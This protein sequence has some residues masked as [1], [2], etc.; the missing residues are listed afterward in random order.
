M[1]MEISTY[2]K[3]LQLPLF[4]GLSKDDL[5]HIISKAKLHFHKCAVHET[6]VEQGKPC[7]QLIFLLNG[8]LLMQSTDSQNA[9]TLSEFLDQPC[10]IEPYSLFGMSPYYT[11]TYRT[12]TNSDLV[13]LDKSYILDE[14][15]KYEVFHINYLNILSNRTQVCQEKLWK[16]FPST[17]EEKIIHF[18]RQR[19]NKPDGEK[20]LQVKMEDLANLINDTRINVSK[21]L[22]EL[23]QKELLKLRRKEIQVFAL[24]KL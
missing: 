10:V 11:A 2:D 6:I 18:L 24:E 20:K 22:K 15:S 8:K 5:T 17:T 7:D 1:P 23:E 13:C 3:L 21:V 4:Q 12:E 16:R 9:Y 19:C 14:L